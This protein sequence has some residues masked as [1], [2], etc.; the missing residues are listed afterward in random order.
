MSEWD[1]L[2]KEKPMMELLHEDKSL[3]NPALF[4][5]LDKIKAEGDKLEEKAEKLDAI[6]LQYGI[7]ADHLFSSEEL[8]REIEGTKL[9]KEEWDALKKLKAIKTHL[10]DYPD[11]DK[12]ACEDCPYPESRKT[13]E[14]ACGKCA[15]GVVKFW[16]E[17]HKKILG[18]D[19]PGSNVNGG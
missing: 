3:W 15:I 4:V 9:L 2:W 12:G 10:E 8:I 17:D 7:T 18:I 1:K 14:G 11:P 13:R 6:T 19:I 16:L 5:L